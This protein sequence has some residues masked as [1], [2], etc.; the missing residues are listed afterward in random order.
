[1]VLVSNTLHQI[2]RGSLSFRE[3]SLSLRHKHKWEP[4][5]FPFLV[6][7]YQYLIISLVTLPIVFCGSLLT[8]AFSIQLLLYQQ[9]DDDTTNGSDREKP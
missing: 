4:Y 1:M 8:K 2:K 5:K 7:D 6:S 3:R 9:I